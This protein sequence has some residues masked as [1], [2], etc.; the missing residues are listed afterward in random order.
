MDKDF[1]MT[2]AQAKALIV[3]LLVMGGF[4]VALFGGAIPGLK[5]NFTEPNVVTVDGGS[6]FDTTF[7]VANPL[8]PLNHSAPQS[9]LFHNV[10]FVFWVTN[11]Y[12][13]TG[14]LVHGNGTEPNGTTYSFV[15]GESPIPPVNTT[16]FFSPDRFFGAS[17]P[18][19]PLAGNEVELLVRSG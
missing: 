4:G 9:V 8:F 16:L 14:G 19:G 18:G 5:P 2:A 13:F 1:P 10:S 11:W 7:A 15:L 3:G 17:W 12:A 6:Y